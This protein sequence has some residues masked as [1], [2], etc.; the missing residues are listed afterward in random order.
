LLLLGFVAESDLIRT[1]VSIFYYVSR[2]KSLSPD[3]SEE[4]VARTG[5]VRFSSL[6]FS[7]SIND[8]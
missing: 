8:F 6:V 3:Y 7:I 2:R 4:T 5:F 1:V